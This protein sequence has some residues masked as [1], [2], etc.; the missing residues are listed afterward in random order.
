M[1]AS[2]PLGRIGD[3]IF[4]AV[5]SVAQEEK[6]LRVDVDSR[7]LVLAVVIRAVKN[8]SYP[9]VGQVLSQPIQEFRQVGV[10]EVG[11]E[12]TPRI[13]DTGGELR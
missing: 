2:V 13:E 9:N 3:P 6:R 5:G 1:T 12:E 8:R 11:D 7:S 4:R 10:T